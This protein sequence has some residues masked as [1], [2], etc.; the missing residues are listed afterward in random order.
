[1]G[2][3]CGK[4]MTLAPLPPQAVSMVMLRINISMLDREILF[5]SNL[6]G[7]EIASRDDSN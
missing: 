6:D 4:A 3:A 1:V 7:Y 5:I 2:W